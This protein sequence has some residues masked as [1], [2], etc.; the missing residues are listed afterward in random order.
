MTTTITDRLTG[1]RVHDVMLVDD[2]DGL[3][4]ECPVC[5]AEADQQC[6]DEDIDGL[7]VELGPW[8]HA[9]RSGGPNDPFG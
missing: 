4:D 5:G 8:I 1:K 7:G 2:A 6:S 9:Q 3:K